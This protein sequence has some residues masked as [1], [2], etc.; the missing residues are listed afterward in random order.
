MQPY[1]SLTFP[2]IQHVKWRRLFFLAQNSSKDWSPF[3]NVTAQLATVPVSLGD[4]STSAALT[5]HRTSP[6][7]SPPYP[8]LHGLVP[9]DL[10]TEIHIT[11]FFFPPLHFSLGNLYI[12]IC[13]HTGFKLRNVLLHINKGMVKAVL[14]SACWEMGFEHHKT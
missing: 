4:Q 1:Y 9:K 13:V 6:R 14:Q 3:W 5:L 10:H 11:G 2:E 7:G 8:I 12:S